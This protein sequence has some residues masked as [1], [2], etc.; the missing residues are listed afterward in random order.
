MSTRRFGT[1][2]GAAPLPPL[3]PAP[4]GSLFG[5]S[6]GEGAGAGVRDLWACGSPLNVTPPVTP[7]RSPRL[8]PTAATASAAALTALAAAP[9]L[10]SALASVDEQMCERPA[11]EA[12]DIEESAL[13][14]TNAVVGVVPV[15]DA[16]LRWSKVALCVFEEAD[17]DVEMVELPL[18]TGTSTVRCSHLYQPIMIRARHVF[19]QQTQTQAR[20]DWARYVFSLVHGEPARTTANV[21]AFV[22]ARTGALVRVAVVRPQAASKLAQLAGAVPDSALLLFGADAQDRAAPS[23]RQRLD[24]LRF[25]RDRLRRGEAIGY[26][27]A[28]EVVIGSELQRVPLHGDKGC[29]AR[30]VWRDAL[31]FLAEMSALTVEL[32]ELHARHEAAAVSYAPQRLP[33]D[34]IGLQNW[35]AFVVAQL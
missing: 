23:L 1:G 34:L 35:R 15:W 29:T 7:P 4:T 2:A 22:D 27:P 19:C 28:R 12:M 11:T 16:S 17:A 21:E 3:P 5:Q 14:C 32:V 9:L 26:I 10:A 33:T 20:Q 13:A 18:A 31:A 25:D 6:V 8:G 24:Q 30:G